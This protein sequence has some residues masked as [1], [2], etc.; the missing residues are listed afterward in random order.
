MVPDLPIRSA[1]FS[2]TAASTQMLLMAW[3]KKGVFLRYGLSKL[4]SEFLNFILYGIWQ[5]YETYTY[6]F[7]KSFSVWPDVNF[8]VLTITVKK[9]VECQQL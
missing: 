9:K 8:D 7:Q 5:L 2:I 3:A 1:L 6:I 4:L